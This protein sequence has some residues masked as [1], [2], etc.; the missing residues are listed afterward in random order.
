MLNFPSN[1]FK[2]C[3]FIFERERQ[4]TSRGGAV[5]EGEGIPNR[6]CDVSTE[7]NVGLDPTDYEI[8]T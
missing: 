4:R 7:P 6:L 8:M 2:K 3:L 1:L 5:R